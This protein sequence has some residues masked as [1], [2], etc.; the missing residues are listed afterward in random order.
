[1]RTIKYKNKGTVTVKIKL[2][3]EHSYFHNGR[4]NASFQSIQTQIFTQKIAQ[5]KTAN[6]Y[7]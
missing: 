1:M 6:N 7:H 2:T 3:Y 5:F 4:L